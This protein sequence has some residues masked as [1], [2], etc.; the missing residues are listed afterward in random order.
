MQRRHVLFL[1][2]LVAMSPAQATAP[3]R[4]VTLGGTVTEIVYALEAG[5]RVVG[6]DDSSLYPPAVRNLPHVG[7]YRGFAIEGVA[8]LR[9]DLVIASDQ[10][11]PPQA[12]EQ[13]RRLGKPV[14]VVPS[15]PNI[16]EL[17]H[18]VEAI[19]QALQCEAAGAELARRIHAGVA[20]ARALQPPGGIAPRVLLFSSHTGRLQAAG[21]DTAANAVLELAGARNA[22]ADQIGYKAI[23]AEAV[24]AL[25]P[26]VIVT[27]TMSVR[28]SDN[29]AAF[30]ALP[31]IAVTPAARNHRIIVMDDL[32]LLGFGPRLPE[33]L[34][35][36]E[37][38][39]RANTGSAAGRS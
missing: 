23:S 8:S 6:V 29:L 39:L 9:P 35:L 5:S 11:G 1:P 27:T 22:F 7:Y 20:R 14:L 19:A 33:A 36:L 3:Q 30:T 10:A 21:R 26:D 31:G 2:L 25:Q 18:A 24:A 17:I 16:E 12:L 38:G 37:A 4:V 13:L 15:A 34:R 32:L 28:A